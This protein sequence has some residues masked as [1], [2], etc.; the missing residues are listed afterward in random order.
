MSNPP[1]LKPLYWVGGSK[2]DLLALPETVAHVFG[3]ALYLAQVGRKHDQAKP[4]KGFGSA[5]VLEIVEDWEGNTY[6]A[7]YT[8]R[9]VE[10]VFVLHVFQKKSKRGAA[11]PKREMDLIRERCKAAERMV[12]EM[13]Q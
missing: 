4:L 3:Y 12:K 5:G 9:F 11:T 2:G 10:G 13:R 7:I 8:V 1:Q 6:R